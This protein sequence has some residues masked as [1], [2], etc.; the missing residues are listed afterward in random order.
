KP[1]PLPAQCPHTSSPFHIFPASFVCAFHQKVGWKVLRR[2][3]P[4]DGP[5]RLRRRLRLLFLCSNQGRG[6]RPRIVTQK[7]RSFQLILID[8]G[9]VLLVSLRLELRIAGLFPSLS[10]ARLRL[11]TLPIWR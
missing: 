11:Q 5:S 10:V 1:R 9:S 2:Y 6:L 4:A 3:S 8:F 7:L